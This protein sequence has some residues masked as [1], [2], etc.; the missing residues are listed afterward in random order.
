MRRDRRDKL[1]ELITYTPARTDYHFQRLDGT[2][3]VLEREKGKEDK[4]IELV[5]D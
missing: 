2:V 3:Y 5:H 1:I 4:W